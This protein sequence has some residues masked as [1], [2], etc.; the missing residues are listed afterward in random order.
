MTDPGCDRCDRS[1]VM[2]A[3]Y[4]G[5][6]LCDEHFLES[7]ERRVRRRIRK[8]GLYDGEDTTWLIGISGGKDSAVLSTILV[9][10]FGDN[11]T[12]TLEGICLHEGIDGYRDASLDAARALA[13]QLDL[14]LTEQTFSNLYG[15]EMDEVAVEDPLEMAPCAYCGVFRRDALEAYAADIGATLLLTGH[16]LDDEAQTALM[17]I[18]EGDLFQMAKHHEAS[19]APLPD[20]R[21]QEEFVPRAKPLREIPEKEVAL[22]AHLRELPVHM[23]TCPHAER[24]FR[25]EVQSLLHRLETNHPGTRH[26]IM[27]GYETIAKLAASDR[28]LDSVDGI[29]S[30]ITCGSPT[31]GDRCRTCEL[32][33]VLGGHRMTGP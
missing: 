17:N 29:E 19:L 28:D 15:V 14:T 12:V 3:A 5:Q 23:A 4:A 22:Y 9:E 33:E 2:H 20:R 24:S 25:A 16:N 27:A 26:S 8:D 21:A 10:T 11:P 6:H 7:V 30:C 31:T 13:D 32:V 18:F 1:A